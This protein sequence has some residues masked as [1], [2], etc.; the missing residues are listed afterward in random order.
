MVVRQVA[1]AAAETNP[2]LCLLATKS[3]PCHTVFAL[4]QNLLNCI[5]AGRQEDAV[6]LDMSHLLL[7]EH[8]DVLAL[9]LAPL[10]LYAYLQS[11]AQLPTRDS[12][13]V[14]CDARERLCTAC[15]L[16]PSDKK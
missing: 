7:V 15:T 13:T 12:H 1:H 10:A 11:S 8:P 4:C 3:T 6:Q 5:L 9:E 16:I 14:D 2:P